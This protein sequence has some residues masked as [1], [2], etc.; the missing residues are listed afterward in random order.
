MKKISIIEAIEDK[1]LFRSYFDDLVTWRNWVAFEKALFG[2]E[3][4]KEEMRKEKN[5]E[6]GN[7]E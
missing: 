2:I 3:L 7:K 1:N 5:K 4:G 6:G